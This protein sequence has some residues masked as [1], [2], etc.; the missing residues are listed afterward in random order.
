MCPRELGC[1]PNAMQHAVWEAVGRDG[2]LTGS[3]T[4]L[5][6]MVP[7]VRAEGMRTPVLQSLEGRY[8]ALQGRSLE[9]CWWRVLT[10]EPAIHRRRASGGRRRTRPSCG[11]CC[12]GSTCARSASSWCRRAEAASSRRSWST[13]SRATSTTRSGAPL[14]R[15]HG[16][17]FGWEHQRGLR[18]GK[19]CPSPI[20]DRETAPVES[21]ISGPN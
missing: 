9:P 20:V 17:G 5:H 10:A 16:W 4:R 2:V 8:Y 6:V 21:A 7:R 3:P 11:C 19:H 14:P 15:V 13:F 18:Q 1:T 12:S